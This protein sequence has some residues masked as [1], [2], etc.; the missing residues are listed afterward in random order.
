MITNN[1]AQILIVDDN[2]QNLKVLG[3]MLSTQGY[4]LIAAQNGT[5]ALNLLEKKKPDLILLDIMMPD[6]D[7]I[8]VC[9]RLKQQEATQHIPVIFITALIETKTKLEAFAA[10][11]VDYI[12]KPFMEEEVLARVN[13]HLALK[14]A[15]NTLKILTTT[16]SMTGVF[17][18]RFA[19]EILTKQIA[20]AKRENSSFVL[21]Y[22]DIDNLKKINDIY[23]HTAGDTLISTIADSL[24]KTVRSSDYIFRVGGDEFLLLFPNAELRASEVLIKRLRKLLNQQKIEDIPIDFSFGFSEYHGGDNISL[25]TL[26]KIAD[27]E[28]Y[29]KKLEKKLGALEDENFKN[30]R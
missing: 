5:K 22:V 28:M 4:R 9:R 19:Y 10:G 27:N 11:G 8:T 7:G 2:P 17:N 18:R 13:V 25:E 24:K 16:D 12:T 29:N 6:I 20:I 21:C 3:E 30:T 14:R 23:G 26:I 15:L 1:A